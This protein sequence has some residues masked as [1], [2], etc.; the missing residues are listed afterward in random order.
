LDII[1]GS[2][3]RFLNSI[4]FIVLIQLFSARCVC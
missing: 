3:L 1:F 4:L 2:I